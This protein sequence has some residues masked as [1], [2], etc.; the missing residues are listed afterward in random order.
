MAC[1][2]N[3]GGEMKLKGEN[4]SQSITSREDEHSRVEKLELQVRE[5]QCSINNLESIVESLI[6]TVNNRIKPILKISDLPD[7]TNINIK[8]H[9]VTPE[10]DN[11]GKSIHTPN[12]GQLIDVDVNT[13]RYPNSH[14]KKISH[15]F[16]NSAA[17]VSIQ[18]L[19]EKTFKGKQV[20][21]VNIYFSSQMHRE[22]G[23]EKIRNLC[24]HQN[25]RCPPLNYALTGFPECQRDVRW[26]SRILG[27]LKTEKKCVAY[28]ISNFSMTETNQ[29][30]PLYTVKATENSQWSKEM[31]CKT[32]DFFRSRKSFPK[33]EEGNSEMYHSLKEMIRGHLQQ[34]QD[35]PASKPFTRDIFDFIKSPKNAG[36]KPKHRKRQ[37]TNEIETHKT[38]S[39]KKEANP[40]AQPTHPFN[41]HPSIPPPSIN[42]PPAYHPSNPPI[43]NTHQYGNNTPQFPLQQLPNTSS[44]QEHF[45][46][47]THYDTATNIMNM[48][49]SAPANLRFIQPE[50]PHPQIPQP[51]IPLA[52][53]PSQTNHNTLTSNCNSNCNVPLPHYH[54]NQMQTQIPPQNTTQYPGHYN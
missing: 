22:T 3:S 2:L 46:P 20:F 40:V 13:W 21:P 25:I 32:L 37:N 50:S 47:T 6:N 29:I 38:K 12:I 11:I 10:L 7:Q 17:I 15:L 51:S 43:Y 18:Q 35:I 4:S 19:K 44:P 49:L 23:V 48:Q 42:Q 36:A 27:E 5:Q 33:S 34:I 52:Q 26:V 1:A 45:L 14:M 9:Y 31:E 53:Q 39:P 30:I 41:P 16:S 8:S 24:K 28:A 54:T